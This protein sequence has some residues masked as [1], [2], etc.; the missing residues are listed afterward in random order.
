MRKSRSL[1]ILMLG[2]ACIF[3]V[4]CATK[5][6]PK[7][8]AGTP[9]KTQAEAEH[10]APRAAG[11]V[12]Q[13]ST[14]SSSQ[15]KKAASTTKKKIASLTQKKVVK[16]SAKAVPAASAQ[17]KKLTTKAAQ[18]LG[19]PSRTGRGQSSIETMRLL[20][21][22]ALAIIFVVAIGATT[23]TRVRRHRRAT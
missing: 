18:W 3:M 9:T 4:T 11:S 23:A 17:L 22:S 13:K 5:G 12:S 14:A 15:K 16:R 21:Y 2:A 10:Q 19:N 7:Q 20:I 6:T 1:A 8:S